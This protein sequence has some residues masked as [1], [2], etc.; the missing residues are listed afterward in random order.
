MRDKNAP[1]VSIRLDSPVMTPELFAEVTGLDKRAGNRK[2]VLEGSAKDRASIVYGLI[3]KGHLP[4]VKLG[5]HRLVNVAAYAA[6]TMEGVELAA[7]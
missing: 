5:R 1:I 2:S 4:S 6:E 7:G 3:E